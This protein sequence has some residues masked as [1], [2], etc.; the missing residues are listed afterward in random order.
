MAITING[1]GTVTGISVGGLP[2]GIVD[3]DMLAAG[4]VT[5]PKS[6]AGGIVQVVF[7]S[8]TDVGGAFTSLAWSDTG[9]AATITPTSSS[10]KILIQARACI[11]WD[12]GNAKVGVALF[13]GSEGTPLLRA[14]TRGN[15]QRV[16]QGWYAPTNSYA[17]VP[18]SM[19]YLDS[20]G[21]T[22]ATTYKVRASALDDAGSVYIN[23]GTNYDNDQTNH[24]SQVSTITLMEV[25]A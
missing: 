19:D 6:G 25:A 18:F 10:N 12:N 21:V 16:H 24:M 5:A 14:D 8:K 20:P 22:S 11:S 17:G 1:N 7:A 13:K 15:R 2:D 9:L 4:A 23:R 3:T